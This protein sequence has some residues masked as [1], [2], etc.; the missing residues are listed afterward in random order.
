M[1]ASLLK[2][3]QVGNVFLPKPMSRKLLSRTTS[4]SS[5]ILFGNV[6]A[7]PQKGGAFYH[8]AAFRL[9]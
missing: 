9:R 2:M 5:T 1:L 8:N 3:L 4:N 7:L 6:A